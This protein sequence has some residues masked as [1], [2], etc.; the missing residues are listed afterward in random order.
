MPQR[1]NN[2]G[3]LKVFARRWL[4]VG[5]QVN[6]SSRKKIKKV[7]E[8]TR[9][10]PA[11]C[12]R[13]RLRRCRCGNRRLLYSVTTRP[14][15]LPNPRAEADDSL[16]AHSRIRNALSHERY[17]RCDPH[18]RSERYVL[19]ATGQT[20]PRDLVRSHTPLGIALLALPRKT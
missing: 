20:S 9:T 18:R 1:C 3:G 13:T 11:R 16:R 14:T 15:V 5:F 19:L 2:V 17:A 8:G 10:D 12:D 7:E 4:A 6:R